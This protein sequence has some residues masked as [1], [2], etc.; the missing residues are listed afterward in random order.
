MEDCGALLRPD[1]GV[2]CRVR[3]AREEDKETY[4]AVEE[5]E[6]EGTGITTGGENF[7]SPTE[8]INLV[9]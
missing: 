8:R 6:E 4:V 7:V 5:E 3:E 1:V 2:V 9:Y